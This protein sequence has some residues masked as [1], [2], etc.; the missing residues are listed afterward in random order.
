MNIKNLF[1]ICNRV[2]LMLNAL[3]A[4]TKG[5]EAALAGAGY[6]RDYRDGG[7]GIT[8][9]CTLPASSHP[10]HYICV[11]LGVSSMP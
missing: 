11:L 9:V 7:D 8:L 6:V 4:R 10:T 1:L 5:H 3:T 2:D